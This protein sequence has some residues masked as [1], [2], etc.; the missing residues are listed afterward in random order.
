MNYNHTS[1][2]KIKLTNHSIERA[3]E[4]LNLNN[5]DEIKQRAGKARFKGIN[6]K[7][8]NLNNYKVL[9]IEYPVLVAL[10]RNFSFRTESTKLFYLNGFIYVFVGKNAM[11]L[12]TIIPVNTKDYNDIKTPL[13]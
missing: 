1:Y 5:Q 13:F 11:T 9:G 4:R 12:K 10:K 2:H 6:V 8:V 3:H 7:N